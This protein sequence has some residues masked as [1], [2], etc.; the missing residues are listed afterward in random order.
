MTVHW[1]QDLAGACQ[2]VLRAPR[3]ERKRR[4][5][6]ELTSFGNRLGEASVRDE[7]KRLGRKAFDDFPPSQID[8]IVEAAAK[9]ANITATVTMPVSRIETET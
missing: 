1:D 2:R 7:F 4:F 6:A 9:E 5:E 3:H 8:R